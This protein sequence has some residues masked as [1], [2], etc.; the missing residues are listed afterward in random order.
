[1]ASK[2]Q[3][4]LNSGHQ[5]PLPAKP[6][7]TIFHHLTPKMNFCVPETSLNTSFQEIPAD[8]RMPFMPHTQDVQDRNLLTPKNQLELLNKQEQEVKYPLLK[9]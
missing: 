8:Y 5:A 1:M 3:H 6:A 4:R 7:A 9:Q 2:T